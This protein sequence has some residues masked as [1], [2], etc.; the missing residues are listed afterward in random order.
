MRYPLK[1]IIGFSVIPTFAVPISWTVVSWLTHCHHLLAALLTEAHLIEV[2]VVIPNVVNANI[3]S[4]VLMKMMIMTR[5]KY[6]N[7]SWNFVHW[8]LFH[9]N[10][11]VCLLPRPEL[12][13]HLSSPICTLSCKLHWSPPLRKPFLTHIIRNKVLSRR[14]LGEW[15]YGRVGVNNK[16]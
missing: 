3:S 12:P 6:K 1:Q 5:T 2:N 13:Q 9:I 10:A 8:H 4:E 16:K 11:Y 14:L 7:T 15:W